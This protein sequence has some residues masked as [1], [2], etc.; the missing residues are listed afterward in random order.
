MTL[1]LRLQVEMLGDS[2]PSWRRCRCFK[3]IDIPLES[4]SPLKAAA[5]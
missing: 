5:E 2:R 3:T 4:K 1:K